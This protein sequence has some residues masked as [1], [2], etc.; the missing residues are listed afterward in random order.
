MVVGDVR[1]VWVVEG[2]AMLGCMDVCSGAGC[3]GE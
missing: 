3:G 2:G 1:M